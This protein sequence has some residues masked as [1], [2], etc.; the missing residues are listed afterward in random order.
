[1]DELRGNRTGLVG[2]AGS[3]FRFCPLT[4]DTDAVELFLNEMT[5]EAVPVPG[6]ALGDAVAVAMAT[7]EQDETENAGS[8][9][10]LLL[11]DGEDHESR[12]LE[13][14]QQAA[15]KGIIIDTI[16]IGTPDGAL[17]PGPY[18]GLVRDER[19]EPVRSKLDGSTLQEMAEITGGMFLRFDSS[20]EGLDSY[21]RRLR[22]RQTRQFGSKTEVLRQER[23]TLFLGLAAALFLMALIFEE[24]DKRR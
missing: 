6:T 21:L 8:K 5:I 20:T 10:I 4:Q 7:F 3:A 9:I 11:T 13:L 1:M 2:F 23:F 17:I 18:G 24:V 19:G 16:G 14:A 15:E 12:P 22:Q